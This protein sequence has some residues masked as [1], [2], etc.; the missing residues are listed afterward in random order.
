[1][2]VNKNALLRYQILDRCFSDFHRKYEIEDLLDK[3]NE[4]LYDLYGTE[5]SIRQIR[6]DIKYMRD[7]VTY[8]APIKAYQYDG[9]YLSGSYSSR[10]TQSCKDAVTYALNNIHEYDYYCNPDGSSIY[11][12]N[13]FCGDGRYNWFRCS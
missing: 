1:M 2:P 5:V 11:M 7:R 3:V 13:S 12:I 8:D 6:D 9:K 10:V 4:A